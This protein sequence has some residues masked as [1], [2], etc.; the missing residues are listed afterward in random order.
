MFFHLCDSIK[1]CP[2][3]KT[4]F[5]LPSIG[6]IFQ[7]MYS[8]CFMFYYVFSHG[9]SVPYKSIFILP[10]LNT[11][12]LTPPPPDPLYTLLCPQRGYCLWMLLGF[13][14]RKHWQLI[15]GIKKDK[16]KDLS[17]WVAPSKSTHCSVVPGASPKAT[18]PM[19]WF[20]WWLCQSWALHCC[21]D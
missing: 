1:A 3:H 4:Q 11:F 2:S 6:T 17:L 12:Y 13:A 20:P 21:P 7:Q 19:R 18:A 15:R 16:L 10:L 8:L 14:N 9:L 5:S